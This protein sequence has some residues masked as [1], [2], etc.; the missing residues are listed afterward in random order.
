MMPKEMAVVCFKALPQHSKA[1]HE[2][3]NEKIDAQL[4]TFNT[5]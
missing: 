4:F 1:G 3:D 2:Q 5:V